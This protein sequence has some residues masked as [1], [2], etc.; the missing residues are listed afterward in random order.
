[1]PHIPM[2]KFILKAKAEKINGSISDD[3][4]DSSQMS[5]CGFNTKSLRLSY[6]RRTVIFDFDQN[7][8][9]EV[10]SGIIED[11]DDM[12]ALW[13]TALELKQMKDAAS[14]IV[15]TILQSSS[16]D[17][18]TYV[19]A[20]EAVYECN[21]RG[22]A[23]SQDQEDTMALQ[24][25]RFGPWGTGLEHKVISNMGKDKIKRRDTLIQLTYEYRQQQQKEN[26]D[27]QMRKQFTEVSR[28]ARLWA[29]QLARSATQQHDDES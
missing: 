8:Y 13:Y 16:P 2:V 3:V 10:Y 15:K 9:H 24:L 22:T 12:S 25:C 27:K 1:M 5:V 17:D 18:V 29:V 6:E 23:S 19:Q 20:L 4:S 11:D 14:M 7:Q 26:D 21:R 28:P